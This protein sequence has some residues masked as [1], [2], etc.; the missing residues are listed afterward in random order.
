MPLFIST[1]SSGTRAM[2][3]PTPAPHPRV[4]FADTHFLYGPTPKYNSSYSPG[5]NQMVNGAPHPSVTL[6]VKNQYSAL[7]GDIGLAYPG[8][9]YFRTAAARYIAGSE[10]IEGY[11]L[12]PMTDYLST[13]GMG[14]S[15]AATLP[16]GGPLYIGFNIESEKDNFFAA[17][18]N[19]GAAAAQTAFNNNTTP[20][21]LIR[22]LL[23]NG[24]TYYPSSYFPYAAEAPVRP[25]HNVG[26]TGRD[27][28][29][30]PTW[31]NAEAYLANSQ[32]NLLTILPDDTAW[33]R[34]AQNTGVAPN[35]QYLADAPF[36]YVWRAFI[37]GKRFADMISSSLTPLMNYDL[38][39]F[40]GILS[41][42]AGTIQQPFADHRFRLDLPIPGQISAQ[43]QYNYYDE[44]TEA[45]HLN[46]PYIKETMLPNYYLTM[47]MATTTRNGS[48]EYMCGD[49]YSNAHDTV[50]NIITL[51]KNV[52]ASYINGITMGN[53][54]AGPQNN[55]LTKLKETD[56]SL[57]SGSA[58]GAN[59]H[60]GLDSKLLG[61]YDLAAD[62]SP[63]LLPNRIDKINEWKLLFPYGINISF[64]QLSSSALFGHYQDI[65]FAATTNSEPGWLR[66]IN[67]GGHGTAAWPS[68]SVVSDYFLYEIMKA[69]IFKYN[70]DNRSQS[71]ASG[72]GL[73]DTWPQVYQPYHLYDFGSK[74]LTTETAF[75][76]LPMEYLVN[77]PGGV[78][79]ESATRPHKYRCIDVPFLFLNADEMATNLLGS[80]LYNADPPGS[81]TVIF[82]EDTG[83]YPFGTNMNYSGFVGQTKGKLAVADTGMIVGRDF[84]SLTPGWNMGIATN[85]YNR[86][87]LMNYGY[88]MAPDSGFKKII[89]GLTHYVESRVRRYEDILKGELA[90]SDVIAYKIEKYTVN[91][92][93]TIPDEPVQTFYFPNTGGVV[94][95]F[96]T[97]VFFGRRYKYKI[98]AYV[99][100]VGNQYNYSDVKSQPH[101]SIGTPYSNLLGPFLGFGTEDNTGQSGDVFISQDIIQYEFVHDA[102]EAIPGQPAIIKS[103]YLAIEDFTQPAFGTDQ[104][105]PLHPFWADMTHRS[106]TAGSSGID[107]PGP[108]QDLYSVEI[109]TT[110]VPDSARLNYNLFLEYL[111]TKISLATGTEWRVRF[112]E[113]MAGTHPYPIESQPGD[114]TVVG[115]VHLE[116]EDAGELTGDYVSVEDLAGSDI[117][118]GLGYGLRVGDFVS[119]GGGAGPGRGLVIMGPASTFR[120][121]SDSQINQMLDDKLASLPYENVFAAGFDGGLGIFIVDGAMINRDTLGAPG[122]YLP[123]GAN[124]AREIAANYGLTRAERFRTL[125]GVASA[126]FLNMAAMST[127]MRD[128]A[129]LFRNGRHGAY[130][131]ITQ[132]TLPANLYSAQVTVSN[133]QSLKIVE[134]PYAELPIMRV[135]DLP[136]VFPQ[137]DI[138]P[139]KGKPNQIKLF[140]NQSNYKKRFVPAWIEPEDE[141]KFNEIREAQGMPDYSKGL[142]FAGDDT[143]IKYEVFRSATAPL[144]YGDFS[145][146]KIKVLTTETDGGLRST[147]ASMLDKI[148]PN[149]EYY[150]CFRTIDKSGF[151]SIPSPVLKVHMVDDNGRMYPIIEPY[152]FPIKSTRSITKPFRRYLEIGAAMG[153]LAVP[154]TSP[155]P[156]S[157]N[158]S[159][160]PVTVPFKGAVWGSDTTFKLRITSKD[161]GKKLDINIKF[162]MSASKNPDNRVPDLP[163]VAQ[164]E[165][166]LLG[167]PTDPANLL[168]LLS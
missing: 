120:D 163:S 67:L 155:P 52:P 20:E 88:P 137:V 168:A 49:L 129:F 51:D 79:D 68:G 144:N 159:E 50:D 106:F 44:G 123:Q 139:L 104:V 58:V 149:I 36:G 93:G 131:T 37:H 16:A 109:P 124:T 118:R 147:T 3:P 111:E 12:P 101:L 72:E 154:L 166:A 107:G 61:G 117:K 2:V 128:W 130:P 82:G 27:F 55:F 141:A 1:G 92:S 165:E 119:V 19:F 140:L 14:E 116:G 66:D 41:P 59:Q 110:W 56:F 38:D 135:T 80:N 45:L 99:F 60:I 77:Y 94:D 96:D 158:P 25:T 33:H 62:G 113:L 43:A 64:N 57:V 13:I 39:K 90:D 5:R 151:L 76:G 74:I 133:F 28:G 136:P 142:L 83:R 22:Y 42:G 91:E 143:R 145:G 71:Y 6:R 31:G 53:I 17:G 156:G 65:Q 121:L 47:T 70:E 26:V 8:P 138:F 86:S 34:D 9:D 32:Y 150:Y 146:K 81:H 11:V 21:T 98:W 164:G 73:A 134:V 157:L 161:T 114:A 125:M 162:Q 115:T 100:V 152:D 103:D 18:G 23:N 102:S 15:S 105:N 40:P 112:L 24:E 89:F 122:R 10:N 48:L 84:N 30:T 126:G 7:S 132:G 97:Q 29:W 4:T 167:A 108:Y 75:S 160:P 54:S 87:F 63:A 78:E 35:L 46:N 85:P 153:Q 127:S 69:N 95:Y 148:K